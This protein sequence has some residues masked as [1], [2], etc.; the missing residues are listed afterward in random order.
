MPMLSMYGLVHECGCP[1]P[2]VLAVLT[3]VS[4][5]TTI[6]ITSAP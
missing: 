5:S 3:G 1:A 2:A 6:A 4:S